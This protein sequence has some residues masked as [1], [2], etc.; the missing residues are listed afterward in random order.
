MHRSFLSYLLFFLFF[1][2]IAQAEACE[3]PAAL[4]DVVPDHA[5]CAAAE[6]E[7]EMPAGKVPTWSG[8]L[9]CHGNLCCDD[10]GGSQAVSAIRTVVNDHQPVRPLHAVQYSVPSFPAAVV[11]VLDKPPLIPFVPLYLRN[12]AFLI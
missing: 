9:N 12:C 4:P 6:Q 7:G 2:A 1:F 3:R 8:T 5:C 10:S 11:P